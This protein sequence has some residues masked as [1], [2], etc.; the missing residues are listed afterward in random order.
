[1]RIAQPAHNDSAKIVLWWF[2]CR[3]NC[4]GGYL[5]IDG[6][7]D[8]LLCVRSSSLF[9]TRVYFSSYT[10]E[11]FESFTV[12]SRFTMSL[13]WTAIAAILYAELAFTILMLMPFI[14]PTTW[15]RFFQSRL[16]LLIKK[17]KYIQHIMVGVMGL[18]LLDAI[19]DV[20]RYTK[21]FV[22][23]S[24]VGAAAPTAEV[25]FH[26]KLFRA[27]RNFYIAGFALFLFYIIK[28]LAGKL[29]YEAQLIIS[30]SAVIKQAESASKMARDLISEQQKSGKKTSGQDEAEAAMK[31]Q[32]L[33]LEAE[34]RAAAKEIE[35]KSKEVEAI[36]RQSEGLTNE[37]D[38]LLEEHAKLQN[39]HKL[40]V[41]DVG[42]RKSD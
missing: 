2:V 34:L 21:S 9:Q 6:E 12:F 24:E 28:S 39:E 14:S 8:A 5:C 20:S 27:Q 13:Q 40:V 3:F 31:A 42:N 37:Y 10:L 7:I 23:L 30:N 29:S 16:V 33:K 15:H 1:M 18:L 38:R 35:A 25:Q 4:A 19:R 17:Y 36:K 11:N 26:M 22:D 41:G 32:V